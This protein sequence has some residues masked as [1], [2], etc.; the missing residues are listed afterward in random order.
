[1]TCTTVYSVII[2]NS[3]GTNS[4]SGSGY[5]RFWPVKSSISSRVIYFNY[6]HGRPEER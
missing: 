3:G 4:N 5:G 6:V 2:S 1:M